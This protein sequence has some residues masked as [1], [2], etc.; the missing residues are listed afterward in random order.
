MIEA[1]D[2]QAWE[3]R[4]AAL[5]LSPVDLEGL[6]RDLAYSHGAGYRY[7][8]LKASPILAGARS[9]NPH[10]HCGRWAFDIDGLVFVTAIPYEAGATPARFSTPSSRAR[11]TLLRR[12]AG[13]GAARPFRIPTIAA[14]QV[15]NRLAA[16]PPLKEVRPPIARQR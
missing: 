11:S 3:V 10:P 8:S 4:S 15:C 2:T 5:R 9:A 1:F 13:V 12:T 16:R 14:V 6:D 7:L